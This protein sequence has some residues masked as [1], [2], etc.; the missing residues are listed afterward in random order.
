MIPHVEF[1]AGATMR[2]QRTILLYGTGGYLNRE[3]G[4]YAVT[5]AVADAE[6]G[7]EPRIGS[8]E[9]V[10]M[11]F[12]QALGDALGVRLPAEVLPE[13]VICRTQDL[14]AWWTP[15]AVRTLFFAAKLDLAALSGEDFPV[16]ALVWRLNLAQRRLF[17]R[18]YAG[19]ARPE[20]KTPLA[21]APF[22]NVYP[23]GLVCQGTM[24]RPGRA[25]LDN[26]RQWEEGFF[27]AAATSQLTPHATTLEGQL[28][29]LWRSLK[30]RKRFP[31]RHLLT[32][33]QA[34]QQFLT[35]RDNGGMS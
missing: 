3:G 16:P 34:T 35:A 18:A 14:V 15:P 7:Q 13:R 17:V 5:A 31:D 33:G 12:V 30:G 23:S 29:A 2:L 9:P 6:P 28:P 8:Y 10:T 27:G 1:G 24:K 22:M 25:G 4:V 20:A 21:V 26:L 11:E 32:A 19:A